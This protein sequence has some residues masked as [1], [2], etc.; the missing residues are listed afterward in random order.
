MVRG[1]WFIS[2]QPW[3]RFVKQRNNRIFNYAYLNHLFP[4]AGLLV[5]LFLNINFNTL[6]KLR[7]FC[8]V[9]NVYG[10]EIPFCITDWRGEFDAFALCMLRL[11]LL[12][13]KTCCRC[14]RLHFNIPST[15]KF[16]KRKEKIICYVN[17]S[18]CM[19]AIGTTWR[20][21]CWGCLCYRSTLVGCWV[22]G[23]SSSPGSL[24]VRPGAHR[25][26]TASVWS[27]WKNT[28]GNRFVCIMT[29]SA[30]QFFF[31]F[32]VIKQNI[33]NLCSLH[34]DVK[35]QTITNRSIL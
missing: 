1:Q 25:S 28:P 17:M 16:K 4:K 23:W 12:Y 19:S 3:N 31:C 14:F 9:P 2:F 24:V 11:T 26:C 15:L 13:L 21:S 27:K 18:L 30:V 22:L 8:F 10:F 32:E 34:F 35:C 7:R 20:R 29:C 5:L 6:F 33:K